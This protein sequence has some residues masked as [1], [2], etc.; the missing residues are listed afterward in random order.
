MRGRRMPESNVSV[1]DGIAI[2]GRGAIPVGVPWTPILPNVPPSRSRRGTFAVA[3]LLGESAERLGTSCV[4]GIHPAFVLVAA[5]PTRENT[6]EKR[7]P[8]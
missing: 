4:V 3:A 8:E 2:R 7:Q 1:K 6:D 5:T